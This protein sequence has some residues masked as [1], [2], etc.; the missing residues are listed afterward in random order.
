[1]AAALLAALS[2]PVG[3]VVRIG[4]EF[5]V[6][7][8]T[9]TTQTDPAV[10]LADD[11]KFVVVWSSFYQILANNFDIWGQRFD[12]AGGRVGGEFLIESFTPSQSAH[13]EVA[14]DADGD[15]V[16]SWE[17]STQ[18]G[19]GII[20]QRFAS[21]GSRQGSEFLVNTYVTGA[22][23]EIS[24]AS[25]TNGDFVIV[26]ASYQD[27]LGL[28]SGLGIFG[29]RFTSSGDRVGGEFQANTFRTQEQRNPWVAA[30]D[31]GDF[32]ITWHSYLQDGSA[33]GVFAK[34]F[35]SLGE[36]IAAEFR[37][38]SVT[39]SV[40][41]YPS[42][43]LDA[44]GDFLV[45]WQ[46]F[47]DGSS[48]GIFGQRYASTGER[49]GGEFQINAYTFQDQMRAVVAAGSDGDFMVVWQGRFSQ[50]GNGGGSFGRRVSFSTG[51]VG[52]EF[53]I[54]T[55][56]TN[57]QIRPFVSMRPGGDF[58]V[59]WH[60][61]NQDGAYNYSIF[62]QR[63]AETG[64]PTPSPTA[65]P[66]VTPTATSTATPTRTVTP[67]R[68]PSVTPSGTPPTPTPT[69]TPGGMEGDIDGDGQG[70][71]LTDGLLIVRFIFGFTGDSLI[72]GAY[73]PMECDRCDS[74]AIANYL[75]SLG[76]QL[77]ID[78][79]GMVQPLTD[80]LLVL[81]YL[82]GFRGSILTS[83]AVDLDACNRCIPEEIEPFISS[84]LD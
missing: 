81:R 40:Q 78:A 76:L 60:S 61:K 20:A 41:E 4:A 51:P 56:T 45:V 69:F 26:W 28:F 80:G 22:K 27:N 82:F 49:V 23:L 83:G 16:V 79:N 38:N 2:S 58:V 19:T 24:V 52:I 11:G 35:S 64:P 63:F 10:A 57:Y 75:A 31:N 6:N 67:T 74:T 37:V 25:E 47:Q 73:D 42:V 14:A 66:T 65:T 84:L 55:Y 72:M 33:R 59:V 77:D 50:D 32:V 17:G 54:N 15:F 36:P 44:D 30:D 48:F 18:S 46:S 43:A 12:A 7:T 8:F 13:P 70:E 53:Q 62:G 5:Q 21:D 34:R 29:Q 3:A 71:A 1:L 39:S 9:P 68:T